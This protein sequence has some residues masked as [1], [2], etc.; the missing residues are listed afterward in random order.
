[1]GSCSPPWGD[2]FAPWCTMNSCH[3]NHE[4]CRRTTEGLGRLAANISG[5]EEVNIAA[6]ASLMAPNTAAALI[7]NPEENNKFLL[8]NA[9]VLGATPWGYRVWFW[10]AIC[11]RG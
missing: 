5:G 11:T 8:T 10:T 3:P 4:P 9:G 1:M 7:G 2:W 6:A